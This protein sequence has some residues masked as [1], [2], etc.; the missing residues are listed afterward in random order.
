[1]LSA[2]TSTC[3][4]GLPSA[5]LAALANSSDHFGSA[6]FCGPA[7]WAMTTTL[8]AVSSLPV[9]RSGLHPIWVNWSSSHQRHIVGHGLNLVEVHPYRRCA[10][11]RNT[12]FTAH[13]EL[14][15]VVCGSM[16]GDWRT[17]AIRANPLPYPRRAFAQP[18]KCAPCSPKVTPP[19]ARSPHWTAFPKRPANRPMT[20]MHQ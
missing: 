9:G 2:D 16:V 12:D 10:F 8:S 20:G 15:K 14:Q 18:V 17:G 3:T 11:E 1:M 4:T 6:N 13:G 5:A 19:A 7:A